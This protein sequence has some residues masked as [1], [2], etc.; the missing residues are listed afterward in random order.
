VTTAGIAGA[1]AGA[2]PGQATHG[3][4]DTC[5]D[6]NVLATAAMSFETESGL[7]YTVHIPDDL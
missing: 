1:A 6:P 2:K 4:S 3:T 7:W 5:S